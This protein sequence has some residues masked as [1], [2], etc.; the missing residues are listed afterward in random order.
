[1]QDD[2]MTSRVCPPAREICQRYFSAEFTRDPVS[3]RTTSQ[4]VLYSVNIDA[5]LEGDSFGGSRVVA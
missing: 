5:S 4:L 3:I 2:S 1:M